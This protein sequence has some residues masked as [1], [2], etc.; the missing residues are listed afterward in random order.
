MQR[1]LHCSSPHTKGITVKHLR[2]A[3]DMEWLN[4]YQKIELI[5]SQIRQILKNKPD[6]VLMSLMLPL[7]WP[8]TETKK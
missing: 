1:M 5:A 4:F 6:K 3:H 8:A 7:Q 2:P